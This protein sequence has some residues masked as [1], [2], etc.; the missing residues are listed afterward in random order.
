MLL[1]FLQ[2]LVEVLHNILLL[3]ESRPF[4]ALHILAFHFRSNTLMAYG[5]FSVAFDLLTL[6][7]KTL[8]CNISQQLL[9]AIAANMCTYGKFHCHG[10]MTVLIVMFG[11]GVAAVGMGF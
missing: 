7:S 9:F 8:C 4:A 11:S 1:Q 3:R 10:L 5:L 2:S 6:T